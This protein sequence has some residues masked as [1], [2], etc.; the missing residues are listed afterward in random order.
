MDN[1]ERKVYLHLNNV[2]KLLKTVDL[3]YFCLKIQLK[4]DT[5]K[6][7]EQKKQVIRI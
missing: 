1:V 6:S 7:E 4:I 3:F 2:F 5:K